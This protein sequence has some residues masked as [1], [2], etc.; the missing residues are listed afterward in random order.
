MKIEDLK[1]LHKLSGVD[2]T[3]EFVAG[4]LLYEVESHIKL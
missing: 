2:L 4:I 1:G 3:T